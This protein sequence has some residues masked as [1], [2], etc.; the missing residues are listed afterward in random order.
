MP[1][2]ARQ[3]I[4]NEDWRQWPSVRGYIPNLPKGVTTYDIHKNL[5]RYGSVEF[6]RIEESQQG[7]FARTANITFK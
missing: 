5:N 3:A 1:V 4:R 6:I 2:A 7:N